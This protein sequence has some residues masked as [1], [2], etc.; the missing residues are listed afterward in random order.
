MMRG[1]RCELEP[2]SFESGHAF[3]FVLCAFTSEFQRGPTSGEVSWDENRWMRT[4]CAAEFLRSDSVTF[5]YAEGGCRTYPNIIVDSFYLLWALKGRDI[6]IIKRH[7][8][9]STIFT[10]VTRKL[11]H[12]AR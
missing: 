8:C 9:S 6:V 3:V 12:S 7:V 10:S 5:S 11:A 4:L 2:H 1:S